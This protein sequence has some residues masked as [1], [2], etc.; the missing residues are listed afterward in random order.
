MSIQ[1]SDT[2]RSPGLVNFT[3]IVG[4]LHQ[5]DYVVLHT[6]FTSFFAR[7]FHACDR[8]I[9]SS[10]QIFDFFSDNRVIY[11]DVSTHPDILEEGGWNKGLFYQGFNE[12]TCSLR[13]RVS[14]INNIPQVYFLKLGY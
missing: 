14:F 7:Y 13:S 4:W 11:V 8:S 10:Q 6:S 9:K 5:G 1:L 12:C 2:F 3:D